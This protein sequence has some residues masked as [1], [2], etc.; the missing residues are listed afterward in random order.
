[1]DPQTGR[2]RLGSF[3]TPL[4]KSRAGRIAIGAGLVGGGCLGFLPV[5][6][7]WMIPLGLIVL[8]QDLASV[9]R[10]RRRLSLWWARR[11]AG[12]RPRRRG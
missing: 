12:Q 3:E 10:R 1:M 4:P 11:R 2:L 5:L 9:R 7:F 8:S 6:G